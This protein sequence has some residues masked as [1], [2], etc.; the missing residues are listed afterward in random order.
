[1]RNELFSFF[2]NYIK[3]EIDFHH[4]TAGT[5]LPTIRQL[6]QY[7]GVSKNTIEQAYQQ[8]IAEGYMEKIFK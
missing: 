8:L 6:S 5:K 4:L 2:I 1:M 3:K 7:L